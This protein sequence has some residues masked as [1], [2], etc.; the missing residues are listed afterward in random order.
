M[1][2]SLNSMMLSFRRAHREWGS[3]PCENKTGA[4]RSPKV[5]KNPIL[6][7]ITT[8]CGHTHSPGEASI[9]PN[10]TVLTGGAVYGQPVIQRMLELP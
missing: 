5:R 3:P 10:L 4:P 7:L 8:L 1:G 2:Y 6:M 9:L